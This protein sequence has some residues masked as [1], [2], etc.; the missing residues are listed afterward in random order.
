MQTL[1]YRS[2]PLVEVFLSPAFSLDGYASWGLDLDTR[3]VRGRY[4]GGFTWLF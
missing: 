2:L 4:L 3:D 1:G